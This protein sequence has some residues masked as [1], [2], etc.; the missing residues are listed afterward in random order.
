MRFDL[1]QGS[2]FP[3]GSMRLDLP[4]GSGF[5]RGSVKLDLPQGSEFPREPVRL[6]PLDVWNSHWFKSLRCL[7]LRLV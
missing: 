1:P 2:E 7:E 4:Q 6:D 5:P 3:R